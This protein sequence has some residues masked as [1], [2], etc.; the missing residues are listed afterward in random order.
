M[1]KKQTQHDSSTI[2]K[3]K[4]EP[5]AL[6][7]VILHNDDYTPMEFVVYILKNSFDKNEASA[8]E[9]MLQVHH[10]GFGIAGLYSLQIAESKVGKVKKLAK[11]YEYPL[12]LSIEKE[13]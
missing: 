2:V 4:T 3:E 12:R 13:S 10:N 1:A 7:K 11:Q 6:Y 9:I 8:N 5:P